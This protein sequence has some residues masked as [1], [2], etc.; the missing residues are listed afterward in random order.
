MK[1]IILLFCIACFYSAKLI[2]GQHDFILKKIHGQ[3]NLNEDYVKEFYTDSFGMIWM[4][5]NSRIL[6][7]NGNDI[8]SFDHIISPDYGLK[9][10]YFLAGKILLNY[11]NR[12]L[13]IFDIRNLKLT[14]VL[15]PDGI[16]GINDISIL[17]ETNIFL[18]FNN[19]SGI[20]RCKL[21]G[22]KLIKRNAITSTFSENLVALNDTLLILSRFIVNSNKADFYLLNTRTEKQ[23]LLNNSFQ[24]TGYNVHDTLVM[25]LTAGK[26]WYFDFK[27]KKIISEIFYKKGENTLGASFCDNKQWIF[28]NLGI[29]YYDGIKNQLGR[30]NFISNENYA[31]ADQESFCIHYNAPGDFYFLSSLGGIYKVLKNHSPIFNNFDLTQDDAGNT[32]I[33]VRSLYHDIRLNEI[34]ASINLKG[35][36]SYHL[37]GDSIF[38]SKIFGHIRYNYLQ[39]L[40]LNKIAMDSQQVLWFCGNIDTKRL[41]HNEVKYVALNRAW[42]IC[43]YG[44]KTWII[45]NSYNSSSAYLS[46]LSSKGNIIKNFEFAGNDGEEPFFWD[47]EPYKDYLFISSTKG[48]LIFDLRKEQFIELSRILPVKDNLKGRAWCSKIISGNLYIAYQDQG[49]RKLNLLT[50][51]ITNSVPGLSKAFQIE[52]KDGKNIWINA[53]DKLVYLNAEDSSF[54]LKTNNLPLPSEISFHGLHMDT[55]GLLFVGGKGGFSIINTDKLVRKI[56]CNKSSTIISNFFV[57]DRLQYGNLASHSNISLPFD[58]NIIRLDIANSLLDNA[59]DIKMKYIL[60]GY[61]KAFSFVENSNHINY[62]NLPYGHYTLDI[63]VCNSLGIWDDQPTQIILVIRPPW[64]YSIL[65]K[66]I[67]F[68][69]FIGLL[70]GTYY[71]IRRSFE[72]EKR[73]DLMLAES[74][75][76][77]IRSQLNPHFVFNSLNSIQSHILSSNTEVATQYLI[78]FAKLLRRILDYSSAESIS[79]G[80][81]IAWIRDYLEL[82]ALRFNNKLKWNLEVDE[83][84]SLH[85]RIPALVIQ[86]VIEN[87]L[88]HGLFPKKNGGSIS[89]SYGLN[90]DKKCFTCDV[91]DDGVGRSKVSDLFRSSHISK[92]TMLTQQRIEYLSRRYNVNCTVQIIDLFDDNGAP[93]GTRV[94]FI[95]PILNNPDEQPF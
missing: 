19:H 31:E 36:N 28:T 91:R 16:E 59:E 41:D 52:S 24:I 20:A 3:Y 56:T 63:F 49:I 50:G 60:N 5:T 81:E 11:S 38:P 75:L 62:K 86:P 17:N 42:D 13:E 29:Y 25:L 88:I 55:S 79:L 53:F 10:A 1:R 37:R 48:I 18:L 80:D 87:A 14:E 67:Y 8:E 78:K 82:E 71:L 77:A 89:I 73:Q 90:P 58:S 32:D 65:A 72:K 61:Y 23:E 57:N 93:A 45:S 54:V 70:S 39:E 40:N 33:S 43:F 95:L 47:I 21:E 30:P 12:K 34:Y 35:I 22:N 27:N 69:L 4:R 74:E 76:K 85:L 94:I 66:I 2:Y 68:F 26:S 46:M 84:L 9:S 7:Y 92:G 6:R 44:G 15:M 51:E 64:Y 83:A